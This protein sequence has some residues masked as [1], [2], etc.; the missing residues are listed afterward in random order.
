M[1]SS[2]R[3]KFCF[4]VTVTLFL[5]YAYAFGQSNRYRFSHLDVSDGLSQNQINSIFK[6]SEGFMWFGTASGLNRFDGHTFKIFKH[7]SNNKNSLSDDVIN[8]IFEGPDKKLW[9]LT[10]KGLCFYDP[11]TEQFN[12]DMSLLTRPLKL[13]QYPWVDK[14]VRA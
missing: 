2:M 14:I 9:M 12:S 5:G 13:P 11:V 8:R 6:D 4:F 1:L 10:R 3:L 7:D